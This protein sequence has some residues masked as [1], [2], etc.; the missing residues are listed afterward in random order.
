MTYD[1]SI[2]S[3]ITEESIFEH[4][5]VP[6]KKGLFCSK[7]RPDKNPTVALYRNKSGHLIMKDFGSDFCGDCFS[8]VSALFNCS[9]HDA[10]L[11]IANDFE[12][13]QVPKL[14]KNKQKLEYSGKTFTEHKS[15]I[16]QVEIR[17]FQKYELDWWKTYG[18]SEET[19]KKF[20]VYSCKNVFLNGELFH[21]ESARQRVFGYYGGIKDGIECWKIYFP[22][23]KRY[24][25]IG[26]WKSTQLQ[27][28]HMLPK[29]GGKYLVI[30][31]SMKD[32]MC[33][34]E[35]GIPAI[36]PNSETLF[37]TEN[38]YQKLLTKFKHI[39]VIY[40][41]DVAGLEG[42][43]KIRKSHPELK[44][45]FIPRKFEAKDFSDFCKK[46]G[47]EEAKNLIKL[48]KKRYF[49]EED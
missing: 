5:G 48:A 2:L 23:R 29:N 47:K 17:N 1:F 20:K 14:T 22:G 27:G 6:I 21:L 44:V 9:F 43:R 41:C 39:L 37:I 46:Y 25:F 19:L 7:L 10:L 24:K 35:F 49:N 4:Y 18:I 11:I 13:L 26:N 40:D 12:L 38:Q 32:V 28:A 36:A 31:K 3:K 33:F 30:T 45:T 8:Y 42:L 15:A 16:I 34:Y